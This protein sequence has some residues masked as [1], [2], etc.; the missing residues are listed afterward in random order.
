MLTVGAFEDEIERRVLGC[1]E[2]G[3]TTVVEK[4]DFH[5]SFNA[6]LKQ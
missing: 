5:R 2:Q 1:S 4:R 6:L 3:F